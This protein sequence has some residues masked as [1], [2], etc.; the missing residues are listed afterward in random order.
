MDYQDVPSS[1]VEYAK[2]MYEE[3]L[4]LATRGN[5]SIRLPDRGDGVGPCRDA[6][7]VG[8]RVHRSGPRKWP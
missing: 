8:G 4:V 1:I 6:N 3:K 2:R 5:I 7:V